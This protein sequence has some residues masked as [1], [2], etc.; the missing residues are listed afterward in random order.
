M[1]ESPFSPKAATPREPT[2]GEHGGQMA[3]RCRGVASQP[4][5]NTVPRYR[6]QLG[7]HGMRTRAGL[8]LAL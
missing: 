3:G 2:L 4:V 8:S 7:T 1:T 5:K 6:V